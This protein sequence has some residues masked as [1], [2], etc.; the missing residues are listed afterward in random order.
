VA[1]LIPNVSRVSAD[2]VVRPPNVFTWQERRR[3][4]YAEPRSEWH[5]GGSGRV[6]R[7]PVS[8]LAWRWPYDASR[9]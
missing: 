7:R 4:W 5:G 1:G 9:M 6:G 2:S 3:A 8:Q